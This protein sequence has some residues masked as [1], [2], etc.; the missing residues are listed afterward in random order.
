VPFAFQ[1]QTTTFSLASLT[2]L[3]DVSL[4]QVVNLKAK[5][6]NVGPVEY[7]TI[8]NAQTLQKQ[9]ATLVD[10]TTCDQHVS[11]ER[12][13]SGAVLDWSGTVTR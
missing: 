5:V 4:E 2:S 8:R 13:W 11:L 12:Y 6:T 10:H 1:E 3:Q 9:G 7:Q